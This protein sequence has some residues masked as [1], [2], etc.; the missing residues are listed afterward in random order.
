MLIAEH[1]DLVLIE[2]VPD[3]AEVVARHGRRQVDAGHL[4][5]EQR[6]QAFDG[7]AGLCRNNGV[8]VFSVGLM[9]VPR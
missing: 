5:D 9:R 2:R 6:M 8:H 1:E 3:R 4:G 7:E